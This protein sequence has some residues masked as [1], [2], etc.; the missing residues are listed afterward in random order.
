MNCVK[1]AAVLADGSP[2]CN[3]CGSPQKAAPT[4]APSM[5]RSTPAPAGPEETVWTGRFSAKAF[6]HWWFLWLLYAG[7]IGYLAFF[8]VKPSQPWMQWAF[9]GVTVAPSSRIRKTFSRWRC[10]SSSPI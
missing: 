8:V 10:M 6:A 3:H 1:C 9:T 7:G 2:F 5:P 4:A